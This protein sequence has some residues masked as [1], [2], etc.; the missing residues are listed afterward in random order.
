[1]PSIL[2][3]QKPSEVR[4]HWS[5]TDLATLNNIILK[6]EKKGLGMGYIVLLHPGTEG[7]CC[8]LC[9]KYFHMNLIMNH[10]SSNRHGLAYCV[11]I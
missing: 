10:I 4:P 5:S 11:S 9:G 1:M 6:S 8:V 2:T 7:T 3:T